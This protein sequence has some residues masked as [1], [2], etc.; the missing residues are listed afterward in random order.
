MCMFYII[1]NIETPL[2]GWNVYKVVTT[3]TLLQRQVNKQA[4]KILMDGGECLIMD[5]KLQAHG[6][7]D[8]SYCDSFAC[9]YFLVMMFH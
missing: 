6:F 8:K 9:L 7:S 1:V 2:N 3:C 4:N 5:V